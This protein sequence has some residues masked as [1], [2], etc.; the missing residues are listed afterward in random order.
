MRR[1]SR[2]RLEVPVSWSEVDGNAPFVSCVL[3]CVVWD[4]GWGC[5]AVGGL[6]LGALEAVAGGVEMPF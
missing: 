4:C 2:G 1:A 6:G 5:E 3:G